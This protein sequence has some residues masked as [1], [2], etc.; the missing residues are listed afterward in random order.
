MSHPAFGSRYRIERELGRGGMATV[1]LA[2]DLRHDRLVAL[3]VLHPELAGSLGP[4]RFLREIA[5]AARLQ[6]PNILTLFDSGTTEDPGGARP[7]YA[8][9]YV[10][11]ESLRDRLNREKQLGMDEAL[12]ITREVAAALSYA[13]EQGVVHRDIKP[14]NVLLGTGQALVADFGI[15]KA[16]D[17]AGGEKLTQ[18]GLSLG[19]PAYMSPEQA[20][21]QRGGPPGRHLQP[22][23]PPLRD[24]RRGSAVLRHDA[25]GGHGSPCPRSGAVGSDRASGRFSRRGVGDLSGPAEG[26]GRPLRL[27]WGIRGGPERIPGN[28]RDAFRYPAGPHQA[29]GGLVSHSR[30]TPGRRGGR[31]VL[32]AQV[33]GRSRHESRG[34]GPIPGREQR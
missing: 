27:G 21:G 2:R 26:T 25:P 28:T 24:A 33:R 19:T 5:I 11:G 4:D 16:L 31:A 10:P 32:V 3:K 22:G 34:G 6:H 30:R 1:Y 15:A 14:E 20:T 18:T 12:R 17:A 29:R 8:M 23:L 7:F 9:P 13:H